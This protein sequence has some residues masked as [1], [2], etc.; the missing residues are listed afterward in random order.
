[1]YQYNGCPTAF[2]HASA[3]RPDV[4]S[5][6]GRKAW[7]AFFTMALAASLGLSIGEPHIINALYGAVKDW[8]PYEAHNANVAIPHMG[9]YAA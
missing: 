4:L 5:G 9:Y 2:P 6:G 1:M 8:E 3:G 7:I